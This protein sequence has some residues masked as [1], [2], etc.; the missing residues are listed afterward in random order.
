[1]TQPLRTDTDYRLRW[2]VLV[3][4]VHRLGEDLGPYPG[5]IE[6]VRD[7]DGY[8]WD[9]SA[10]VAGVQTLDGTP[11]GGTEDPHVYYDWAVPASPEPVDGDTYTMTFGTAGDA[12]L[13]GSTQFEVVVI[14]E[15]VQPIVVQ[16]ARGQALDPLGRGQLG[17][18]YGRGQVL[19]EEGRAGD[20]TTGRGSVTDDTGRGG[21]Y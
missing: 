13:T 11:A 17:S 5:T 8:Y 16:Q 1:M 7:G 19:D 2:H 12:G 14:E 10:F 21:S 3:D 18:L 6:I 9:G 20:A 4:G 15:I